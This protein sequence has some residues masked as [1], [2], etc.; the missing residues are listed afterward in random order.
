MGALVVLVFLLLLLSSAM[1]FIFIGKIA[2]EG[3]VG[4]LVVGTAELTA[5]KWHEHKTRDWQHWDGIYVNMPL[6]PEQR[7]GYIEHHMKKLGIS[8]KAAERSADCEGLGYKQIYVP[9][10][11]LPENFTGDYLCKNVLLDWK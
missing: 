3:F 7:E 2:W 9:H 4:D 5:A 6:T 1:A 11:E 8:R 10:G